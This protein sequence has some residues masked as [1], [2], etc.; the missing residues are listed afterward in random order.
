MLY[1]PTDHDPDTW[2]HDLLKRE[3]TERLEDELAFEA[4]RFN[5]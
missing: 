5:H 2:L 1:E 4:A 3:Y